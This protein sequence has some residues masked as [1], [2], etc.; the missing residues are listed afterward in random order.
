MGD[1][2]TACLWVKASSIRR[3]SSRSRRS[4]TTR[5][6]TTPPASR[7]RSR[8]RSPEPGPRRRRCRRRASSSSRYL[9]CSRPVT[10]GPVRPCLS[11]RSGAHPGARGSL[12]ARRSH[13]GRRDQG[14]GRRRD[15]CAGGADARPAGWLRRC[16]RRG[17]DPRAPAGAR[18]AR[19]RGREPDPRE[20]E[21]GNEAR[22][23]GLV[24]AIGRDD[25][26]VLEARLRN[27]E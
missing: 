27:R 18:G 25:Q 15:R 13:R 3:S 14:R 12:Y 4:T 6:P 7:P 22:L 11:P 17:D 24:S 21:S 10:S 26:R 23:R 5:S 20:G 9:T 8:A 1:F 2:V 16:A 19:E